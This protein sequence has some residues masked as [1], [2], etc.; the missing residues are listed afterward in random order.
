M[1]DIDIDNII[2]N[3]DCEKKEQLQ[4]QLHTRI[5]LPQQ[6]E[7]RSKSNRR[8]FN[9]KAVGF[10]IAGMLAVC[11]AIVLPIS[12]RNNTPPSQNRYTYTAAD[13]SQGKLGMT[14]KE[15]SESSRKNIL[16][17]DWYDIA[18][19]CESTKYFLPKEEENIIYISESIC[20]GETGDR[21]WF[22]VVAVNISVD[23]L[24][25]FCDNYVLS[26]EHNNTKINWSYS[27]DISKAYFEY[28]GYK[29]Y[30]KLDYPM[31]EQAILDIVK[32]MF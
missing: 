28:K 18:D 17:L 1:R 7:W 21:V 14:I 16:Y 2:E 3:A 25:D 32:E 20:N 15:Y 6:E 22:A 11:L 13:F 27:I 19:E 12:L 26:Y 8:V 29:Y 10:G 23:E 4:A 24:D 31:S 9:L 5:G 30:V